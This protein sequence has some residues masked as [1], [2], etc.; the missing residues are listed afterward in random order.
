ME[1]KQMTRKRFT[2]K[3]YR[4]NSSRDA[5]IMEKQKRRTS[6]KQTESMQAETPNRM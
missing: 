1:T 3:K 4:L 6:G 2:V 5:K